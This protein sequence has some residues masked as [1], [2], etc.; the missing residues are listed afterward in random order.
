MDAH[1]HMLCRLP[2]MKPCL[3]HNGKLTVTTLPADQV[4]RI[5]AIY[6]TR[7]Q[8][9]QVGDIFNGQALVVY[10]GSHALCER[11]RQQFTG[12]QGPRTP[13]IAHKAVTP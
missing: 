7:G 2:A 11:K 5:V 1:T 3:D 4:W 12:R 8:R 13:T 6:K 10:T 9:P